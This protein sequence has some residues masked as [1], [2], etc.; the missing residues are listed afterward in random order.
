MNGDKRRKRAK[1]K[2]KENRIKRNARP[3]K[4]TNFVDKSELGT[5]ILK[6]F[7][8]FVVAVIGIAMIA[9]LVACVL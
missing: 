1:M 4:P 8:V 6:A 2:D 7:A 9:G 3:P 5:N